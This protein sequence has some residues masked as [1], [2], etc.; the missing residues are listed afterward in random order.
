[1]DIKLGSI[2]G[3]V[4]IL[5]DG[6]CTLCDLPIDPKIEEIWIKRYLADEWVEL[7]YHRDCAA[8]RLEHDRILG[9]LGL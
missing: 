4:E 1:M 7:W 9:G 8:V 5:H 6:W 2:R 3:P